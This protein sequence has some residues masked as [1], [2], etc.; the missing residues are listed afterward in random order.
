MASYT[1]TWGA[2]FLILAQPPTYPAIPI[3]ASAIVHAH[4]EANH[5]ILVHNFVAYKAAQSFTFKFICNVT[6]ELC[7][8]TSA[9]PNP[10][11]PMQLLSSYSI[12]LTPP[13]TASI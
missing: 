8:V 10:S 6:N 13:V 11:T 12:T 2:S 9:T 7:T 1:A 4:H 3:D 5:A